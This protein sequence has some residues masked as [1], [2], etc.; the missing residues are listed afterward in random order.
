[1]PAMQQIPEHY[2]TQFE[3]NWMHL[4]QQSESRLKQYVKLDR[5]QGKEKRYNQLAPVSMQKVTARAGQTRITDQPSD[6]RWLR[7][8]PYDLA[9]LFD[10]FDSEFLGQVVLPTSETVKNHAMAYERTCDEVIIESLN[11]VAYTGELG[12]TP[13][14][15]PPTRA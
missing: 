1:M 10:E 3:T 2:V 11:G 4:L 13:A 12:V 7:P 9:T 6:Q 8:F 5:V 15:L 14:T